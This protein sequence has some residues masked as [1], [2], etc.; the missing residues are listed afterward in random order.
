MID[1]IPLLELSPAVILGFAVILLFTGKL[2]TN[3]AYQE[4]VN[5]A[6]RW[7]EAYEKE[8][9]ARELSDRQTEELLEVTKTTHAFIVAVFNNSEIIRKSGVSNA[10]LPEEK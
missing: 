10:A 4:K 8:R 6:D 1:G 9:T 5:E 7:R 3:A 2:W